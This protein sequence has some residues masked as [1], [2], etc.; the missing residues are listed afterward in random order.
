M[1]Q[2]IAIAVLLL[3]SGCAPSTDDWIRQ[4]KDADVVKKREALRAL[5]PRIAEADRVVP[6]LAAA[7]ADQNIYVRRDAAIALAKFGPEAREAVP[8]LTA[9]LNDK[10]QRLREMA[11]KALKK[12]DVGGASKA[13]E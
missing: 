5:G 11:G 9:A 3:V 1:R 2:P 8:A 6:A 13:V 4:S 7:L 10:D 12:I